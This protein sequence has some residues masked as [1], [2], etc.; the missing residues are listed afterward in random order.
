[1]SAKLTHVIPAKAGIQGMQFIA[2]A[3]GPRFRAGDGEEG[4]AI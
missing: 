3:L 1:M 4:S 2:V